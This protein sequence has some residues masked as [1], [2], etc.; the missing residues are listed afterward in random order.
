[1]TRRIWGPFITLRREIGIAGQL[2][3]AHSVRLQAVRPRPRHD[4]YRC[5]GV[6]VSATICRFSAIK[7]CGRLGRSRS[8]L[9]DIVSLKVDPP[10]HAIVLS[11]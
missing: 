11:R 5:L 4:R 1:M 10:V 8:R 6:S 9:R 7:Y 3:L 2:E